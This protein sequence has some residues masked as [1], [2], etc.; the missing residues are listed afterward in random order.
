MVLEE[1]VLY[2]ISQ[3]TF[4]E[5][6]IK[7]M[8]F[9]LILVTI[10]SIT[11]IV[12]SLEKDFS[13]SIIL[14]AI[15]VSYVVIYINAKRK[16]NN[17]LQ[18]GTVKG[19]VVRFACL[20]NSLN[21]SVEIPLDSMIVEAKHCDGRTSKMELIVQE[22][23]GVKYSYIELATIYSQHEFGELVKKIKVLQ[24]SRSSSDIKIL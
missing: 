19:Q 7:Q 9:S 3:K 5:K 24:N 20:D 14:L 12:E 8:S 10:I 23:G 21:K 13:I 11:A 1:N 4:V 15:I 2:D 6:L 18:K 22:K 17:Q 16:V